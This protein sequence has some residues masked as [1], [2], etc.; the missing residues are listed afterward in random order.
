MGGGDVAL[1]KQQPSALTKPIRLACRAWFAR[2]V[3]A[4]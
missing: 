4:E 1:D 3:T 2:A